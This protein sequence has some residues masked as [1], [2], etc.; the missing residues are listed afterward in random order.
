MPQHSHVARAEDR[1]ED[2]S[3]ARV[4]SRWSFRLVFVVSQGNERAVIFQGRGVT[5]LRFALG[6]VT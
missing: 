1:S 3:A 2:R 4:R 5:H 6:D